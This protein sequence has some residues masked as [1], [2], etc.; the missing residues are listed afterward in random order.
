MQTRRN[1]AGQAAIGRVAV[2]TAGLTMAAY[3]TLFCLPLFFRFV[4]S[5]HPIFRTYGLAIL[6]V[7][8]F[9]MI[10][11]R[12]EVGCDWFNY[13]NNFNQIVSQ[14]L[15]D[16]FAST[17]P[18]AVLVNL[19]VD[20]L[21]FDVG[22]DERGLCCDFCRWVNPVRGASAFSAPNVIARRSVPDHSRGHGLHAAGDRDWCAILRFPIMRTEASHCP[23]Y[24][25]CH[26][27]LV[28]PDGADLPGGWSPSPAAVAST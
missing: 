22:G 8:L 6:T 7:V 1:A 21:G 11:F 19:A 28:S 25:G 18:G 2:R 12:Y 17:E 24:L 27:Q 13:A 23:G 4:S 15:T 16:S 26:R 5:I 9:L 20:K 14:P 3:W 10:G